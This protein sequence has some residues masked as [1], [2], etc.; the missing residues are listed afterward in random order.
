MSLGPVG[1]FRVGLLGEGIGASLSP[2]M[3][4]L[5]GR[6][7]GLDYTYELF[8]IAA[9]TFDPTGLAAFVRG[10]RAAGF[11][12]L[13]V[14]HPYKQRVIP[15][16]NRLSDDA[17]SIGAVNLLVFDEEGIVGHNTDWTGFSTSFLSHLGE[18]PRASVLQLGAGGAGAATAY[19][20]LRLGVQRLVIHDL[21]LQRAQDLADRYGPMFLSQ[22]V[23]ASA[24]DLDDQLN[25]YDGVVHATPTGMVHHP[26]RPFDPNRLAPDAWIA[27]VVYR[28]LDT[29]L[30]LAA[31]ASGRPVMDGGMMAAGQAI[32]SLRILTGLVPDADRVQSDL[33]DLLR[34]EAPPAA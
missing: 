5:E 28:P 8:D 33:L 34:A 32:D 30:V 6:R 10:L 17:R 15:F 11:D 21:D 27:E 23:S 18:A 20:L 12:G 22:T 31:R 13:N 2:A 25:R 7:L 14:T 24:G 3:H 19:A 4:M 29:E 1:R 9:D 16:V 26:G